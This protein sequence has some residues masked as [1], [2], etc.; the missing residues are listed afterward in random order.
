MSHLGSKTKNAELYSVK[1]SLSCCERNCCWNKL[2]KLLLKISSPLHLTLYTL[3]FIYTPCRWGELF[4]N[5]IVVEL[6]C[7]CCC[8]NIPCSA[9]KPPPPCLYTLNWLIYTLGARN[10][11]F[12]A[13]LLLKQVVEVVVKNPLAFTPYTLHFTP[14]IL[15]FTPYTLHHIPWI[16][17]QNLEYSIPCPILKKVYT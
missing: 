16:S 15:A 11:L 5:G 3:N 9:A 14:I 7:Y 13:Q 6:C 17:L 12:C 10:E 1:R 2:L 4:P 8:F